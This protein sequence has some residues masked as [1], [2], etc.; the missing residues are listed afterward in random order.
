MLIAIQ[1]TLKEKG[2]ALFTD[3]HRLNIVGI[4]N[5]NPLADSFDDTINVFY[6]RQDGAWIFNSFQ[7]TTDPGKHWLQ[8]PLN[9]AG[10][11]ILKPGQYKDAYQIGLHRGKYKALVQK[12]PVTVV[13]DADLNKELNFHSPIE[14]TGMFGINI[15]H[16]LPYGVTKIVHKHSA[17]CQVFAAVTDFNLLME[18]ANRHCKAYGNSF[19]YTL[20]LKSDLL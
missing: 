8:E 14:Q 16:A 2:Y 20:L 10:A 12:K 9:P 18:L 19:T 13:R 3:A 17:G 11:A 5:A 1:Q 7:A 6:A 4:R 15:H